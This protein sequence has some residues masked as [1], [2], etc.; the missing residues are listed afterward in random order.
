[1]AD[2]VFKFITTPTALSASVEI[3]VSQYFNTADKI[4][5]VFCYIGNA[6]DGNLSSQGFK[7][8]QSEVFS[9]QNGWEL[10][11][12]S[13]PMPWQASLGGFFRLKTKPTAYVSDGTTSASKPQLL[14]TFAG[15]YSPRFYLK[16]AS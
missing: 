10:R 16:M 1:M 14:M 8:G 5:E 13:T 3:D 2:D 12:F 11:A 15:S 6:T 7:V 9:N 4:E